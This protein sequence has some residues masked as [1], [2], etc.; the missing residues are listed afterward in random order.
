MPALKTYSLSELTSF[1]RRVFALNLPEA[2]WVT[3]ELG[4]VNESRGHY[5]L[6]LVEKGEQDAIAAQLEGVIWA[7]QLQLL[8]RNYGIKLLRDLLQ[9][10]MS[11]KLKVTT[12]FHPRYG[13]KVV[14][15]DVDP[16]FTIGELE[17]KRKAVLEQLAKEGLLQ[18]NASLPFPVLPQRLAVISSETAAGLADFRQQ[19]AQNPYGYQFR[20]RLFSAA[21]QGGNTSSEI[22][23]RLR[24]ISSQGDSF[25][26]VVI[27]RGGGGRTDLAAFDEASLCRAVAAYPLPVIVGI[28][29]ET[30]ESVLDQVA[31]RSLKTPTATATFL[32][33]QLVAAEYNVLHLGRGIVQHSQHHLHAA[34]LQLSPIRAQVH[35]LAKNTVLTASIKL[36]QLGKD[37]R[38][39]EENA[40]ASRSD[41]LDHLAEL[42]TALRPEATLARGY[43]LASQQGKL[44]I[45][46]ASVKSGEVTLRLRDG[47]ITLRKEA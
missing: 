28:G 33:E 38:A 27:I 29:H 37:L 22:L 6:T 45:D 25:D 14:V 23:T 10:G 40:L 17:R 5:W 18:K 1:I 21:M 43:A 8:Q 36:A 15:E 12:S 34:N 35:Q 11:I 4:Q 9:D 31:A 32:I 2:V 13:L 44:L 20:V 26:A 46:P 24:Q 41:Q 30:D 7:S 16:S 19:L 42:L 47:S 3:A 39:A